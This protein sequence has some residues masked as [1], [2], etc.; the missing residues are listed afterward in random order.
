MREIDQAE[1]GRRACIVTFRC[2]TAY[3][4][5]KAK[6]LL[7][8]GSMLC[9]L[10]MNM[11]KNRMLTDRYAKFCPALFDHISTHGAVG[12]NTQDFLPLFDVQQVGSCVYSPVCKALFIAAS[13]RPEVHPTRLTRLDSRSSAEAVQP[14]GTKK[15]RGIKPGTNCLPCTH[16][17][18]GLFL[19]FSAEIAKKYLQCKWIRELDSGKWLGSQL[20][21]GMRRMVQWRSTATSPREGKDNTRQWQRVW[22]QQVST[23]RTHTR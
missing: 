14:K 22:N 4:T 12:W 23:P 19:S 17:S 16:G 7:F 15:K 3:A 20:W 5:A 18:D 9:M 11:C 1:A 10:G 13:T 21:V 2:L 6:P 8:G